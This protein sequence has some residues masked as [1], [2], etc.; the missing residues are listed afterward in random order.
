VTANPSGL[1]ARYGLA[2]LAAQL[3]EL[4]H[5]LDAERAL[6]VA[7]AVVDSVGFRADEG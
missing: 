6:G 1:Q 7:P 4:R 3:G 5:A 2:E